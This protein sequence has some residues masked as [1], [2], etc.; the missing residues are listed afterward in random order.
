MDRRD[1]W[2]GLKPIERLRASR[3]R[4]CRVKLSEQ[5]YTKKVDARITTQEVAELLGIDMG[6]LRRLM[7]KGTIKA[8]PIIFDFRTNSTGRTWSDDDIQ[9]ARTALKGE[10]VES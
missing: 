3:G 7:R 9:R 1:V 8:P 6:T 10:S 4:Q 2:V 5:R